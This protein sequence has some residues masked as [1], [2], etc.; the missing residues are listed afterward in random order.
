MVACTCGDTLAAANC[1]VLRRAGDWAMFDGDKGDP[2]LD[3]PPVASVPVCAAYGGIKACV[4]AY[5]GDVGVG[6][7]AYVTMPESMG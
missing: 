3:V 7:D 6:D 5:T 2:V 4:G 1:Y